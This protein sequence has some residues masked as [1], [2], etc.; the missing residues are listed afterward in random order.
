[1]STISDSTKRGCPLA[2]GQMLNLL[3]IS[4]QETFHLVSAI[5]H[6][7]PCIAEFH[8]NIIPYDMRECGQ[9][10]KLFMFKKYDYIIY[11]K[12][13]SK[14]CSNILFDKLNHSSNNPSKQH[15][16]SH[17]SIFL[18]IWSHVF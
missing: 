12:Q 17:L 13:H 7:C 9:Q 11:Q 1:M 15:C 4:I 3:T 5:V 16:A 6:K 2:C 18:C 14:F 8:Q 10:N